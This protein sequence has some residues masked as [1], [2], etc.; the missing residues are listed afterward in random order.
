MLF[1]II[2]IFVVSHH[3][4]TPK[5][6]LWIFTCSYI[7]RVC[8]CTCVCVCVCVYLEGPSPYGLGGITTLEAAP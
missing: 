6:P 3:V 4:L 8:M 7:L 5:A 1:S 2:V